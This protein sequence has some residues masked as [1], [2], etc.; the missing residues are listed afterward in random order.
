MRCGLAADTA[1]GLRNEAPRARPI[2]GAVLGAV[3]TSTRQRL[4]MWQQAATHVSPL[5]LFGE[6]P[7]FDV[8]LSQ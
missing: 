2:D 4:C 3:G 6:P 7:S 5:P 1:T 8:V